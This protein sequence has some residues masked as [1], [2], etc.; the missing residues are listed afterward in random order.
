MLSHYYLRLRLFVLH[1]ELNETVICTNDQ[2]QVMIPGAFFLNKDPPVYVR[3]HFT[4]EPS[5]EQ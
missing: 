2:M 4:E 3:L 1:A 5:R